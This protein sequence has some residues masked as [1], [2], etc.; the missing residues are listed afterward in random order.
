MRY[1]LFIAQRYLRSKKRTG[2]VSLITYISVAGVSLGVVALIV[3]LSMVNGFEEEVRA[4]IVGTNAHLILLSYSDKGIRNYEA[5][6]KSVSEISGVSGSAPFI[7]GKALLS[8]G[9][10]SD[11]VIVKGVRL[12]AERTVTTVADHIEPPIPD[13]DTRPDSAEASGEEWMPGIVL[14]KHVAENLRA[15]VGDEVLLASPFNSRATPLG[16]IPRVRKFRLAG[17]FTSGLYE[18]DAS[19]AYISL[20]EGQRFF[21]TNDAVTGIELKIQDMFAAASYEE[22][23]LE[24]LGGYPFRVNTWIELN[25]NLFAWMRWEKLGMAILLLTIVLVAAFNIVSALIMVVMEKRREIGILKSMG[26]TSAEV[27]RIFMAEGLVIGGVGTVLGSVLG[28]ALAF[29]LDRY[30][31]IN[32]PG[33]IYFLDTLPMKIHWPDGFAITGATLVLCF[34]ATLYPSWKAAR[35]DPVDAI[36]ND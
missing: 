27:M 8:V 11:G 25:E 31:L 21:G 2:F 17:I 16:V 13:F 29:F 33:D 1:E 3:V 35:L 9:S 30:K 5:V 4:R 28:Y 24:K 10:Q 20:E 23:V 32:L 18:Y 26:A 19:L 22:K 34:L 7:Y 36:R 14:G 6:Q 12:S 15:V